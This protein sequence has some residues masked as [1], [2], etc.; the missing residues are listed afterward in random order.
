MTELHL[1][2]TNITLLCLENESSYFFC[3]CNEETGDCDLCG[4]IEFLANPFD[5]NFMDGFYPREFLRRNYNNGAKPEEFSLKI[6]PFFEKMKLNQE[7][8]LE[9]FQ[10][11][12][13]FPCTDKNVLGNSLTLEEVIECDKE[14]IEMNEE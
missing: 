9:F 4:L 12:Y 11:R 1:E 10:Q 8:C 7:K 14:M 2:L 6:L 13:F 5:E 3:Y